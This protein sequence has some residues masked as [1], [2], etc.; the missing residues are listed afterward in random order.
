MSKALSIIFLALS[1][2]SLICIL[3]FYDSD[4]AASMGWGVIGSIGAVG[5]SITALT[6]SHKVKSVQKTMSIFGVVWS[7]I[8]VL[9]VFALSADNEASAGWG[10]FSML[11]AIPFAIVLIAKGIP[12]IQN[13]STSTDNLD[14][15]KVLHELYKS[16]ALTEEEYAKKKSEFI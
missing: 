14:K 13:Q 8:C 6:Q 15:I 3:G 5:F 11:Y 1:S 2:L 9:L 10:M 7:I 12:T 16:G 4:S